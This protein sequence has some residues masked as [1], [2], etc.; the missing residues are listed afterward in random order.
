MLSGS[1]LSPED[2]LSRLSDLGFQIE[3]RIPGGISLKMR[4]RFPS[5]DIE[6]GF[7]SCGGRLCILPK[8]PQKSEETERKTNAPDCRIHTQSGTP[9]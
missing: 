6:F 8:S 3:A 4:N 7:C 1:K 5:R 2:T 9:C